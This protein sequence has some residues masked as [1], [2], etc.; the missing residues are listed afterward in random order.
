MFEVSCVDDNDHRVMRL[1]GEVS[2][3]TLPRFSDALNRELA[4][5]TARPLIIDLD[6]VDT[7]D[8]AGLGGQPGREGRGV[9]LYLRPGSETGVL[10]RHDPATGAQD[11]KSYGL[12]SQILADL[13]V[14][15]M[16]L[17]TASPDRRY[18]VDGFGLEIRDVV[19]LS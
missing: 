18:A 17:L 10:N 2:L 3:A 8:D 19:P 11:P 12:G 1:N 16:R 14:R 7:L 9:V 5:S 4:S 13:G 6:G 15:S